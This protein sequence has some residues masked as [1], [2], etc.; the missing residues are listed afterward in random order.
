[1]AR[2]IGLAFAG[3]AAR[4]RDISEHYT[5]HLFRFVGV[6]MPDSEWKTSYSD[7]LFVDCHSFLVELC[8]A[9]DH[10]ASYLA[11]IRFS[12]NK[13]D[14]MAGLREAL[15][16]QAYNTDQMATKV[17]EIT[18]HSSANGWLARLSRYRNEIV[19]RVPL[20]ARP[21]SDQLHIHNEQ[22][23]KTAGLKRVS[24]YIRQDPCNPKD[25]ATCDLLER[26]HQMYQHMAEF[27]W[28]VAAE[29]PYM[30]M[31]QILDKPPITMQTYKLS[32]TSP[33]TGRTIHEG[34][35]FIPKKP[36]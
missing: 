34:D 25:T 14:S 16:K 31:I 29:S 32:G 2:S 8:T 12:L 28:Q 22:L 30:P 21:E 27:S 24:L 19:H 7:D 15:L 26:F 5:S 10:L 1:L 4:L 23:T 11:T 20:P 13:V 17:L 6:D 9:R 33:W 18:D 35:R 3:A 36:Q